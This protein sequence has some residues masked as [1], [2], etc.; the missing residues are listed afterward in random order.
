MVAGSDQTDADRWNA[1]YLDQAKEDGG[2]PDPSRFD[3][4]EVVVRLASHLP[5]QGLAVDLAGGNGGA[6]L[7]FGQL[8][9]D[10]VLVEVSDV[11]IAQASDRAAE[12]DQPLQTLQF[13]V[14]GRTLGE[15]L[16]NLGPGKLAVVSCFHYLERPLLA[17]IAEDLPPGAVFMASIAT[18]TNLERNERPAPRFLLEPGELLA[19]VAPGQD[20]GGLTVLHWT[21][22]WNPG[23]HHEAELVVTR[24]A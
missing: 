18:T 22:H 6:A 13:D 9:L 5:D 8:G 12:L 11:A 4:P 17:S 1:R 3:P 23:E 15:V 20:H 24:P 10:P 21:E 16:A 7:Y 19:L 14:A 2:V